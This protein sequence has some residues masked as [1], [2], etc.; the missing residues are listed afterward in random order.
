MSLRIRLSRG[1]A[2]KRPFYK[3]IVADSRSARDS[4][5]IEKVGTYNPMLPKEHAQRITLVE[6]RLKYWLGE[7]A[8]PTDRVAVFLGNAGL[9]A[10]PAQRNNPEKAKPKAKAQERIRMAEE[11]VKKAEETARKAEEAA[12]EA[13]AAAKQAE[14]D[15]AAAAKATAEAPAEAVAE[16]AAEEPAAEAASEE[17]AA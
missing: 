17:T 6:D 9:I 4:R 2:K 1:G 3:I 5:F 12:K 11:A 14:I 13:A 7:G 10:A 8:Q 16:I 15:A